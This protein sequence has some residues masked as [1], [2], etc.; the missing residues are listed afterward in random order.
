MRTYRIITGLFLHYCLHTQSKQQAARPHAAP[1]LTGST[2]GPQDGHTS[3]STPSSPQVRA[4]SSLQLNSQDRSGI[5]VGPV[6]VQ[7]LVHVLLSE[8]ATNANC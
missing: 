2:A 5:R 4:A 8:P 7:V 3:D 1:A 6:S